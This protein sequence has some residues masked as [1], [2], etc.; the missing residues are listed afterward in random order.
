[1]YLFNSPVLKELLV[2]YQWP[3]PKHWKRQPTAEEVCLFV[4]QTTAG[5]ECVCSSVCLSVCQPTAEEMCLFSYLSTYSRGGVFVHWFICLSVNPQ[6]RSFFYI[7]LSH[8]V[9]P[10]QSCVCSSVC[11]SVCQPTAEEVFLF[12]CLSVNPQERCL[13][14]CLLCLSSHNR[15][16]V[17]VWHMTHDVWVCVC[18]HACVWCVCVH[19]MC[20]YLCVCVCKLSMMCVCMCTCVCVCVRSYVYV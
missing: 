1:M 2:L 12:I 5:G 14:V 11:V 10:Q 6:Q 3:G 16:G 8:S 15:W 18:V 13:F 19:V 9:N 17:F 20:V 7:C 4:C